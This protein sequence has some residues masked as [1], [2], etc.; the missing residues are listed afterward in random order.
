MFASDLDEKINTKLARVDEE[1]FSKTLKEYAKYSE[2]KDLKEST[3]KKLSERSDITSKQLKDFVKY[4]ELKDFKDLF[5]KKL[6]DNDLSKK[7]EEEISKRRDYITNVN[8]ETKKIKHN[9]SKISSEI[10]KVD[11]QVKD[12]ANYDELKRLKVNLDRYEQNINIKLK[13]LVTHEKLE[14]QEE[15]FVLKNSFENLEKRLR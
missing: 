13:E 14:K 7:L 1:V 2:L 4:D 3:A 15:A 9:I 6:A 5:F 10:A 8:D 12:C 11:K